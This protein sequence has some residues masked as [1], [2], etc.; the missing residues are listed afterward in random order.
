MSVYREFRFFSPLDDADAVRLSMADQHGRE[1]FT[2]VEGGYGKRWR[3]RRE[4][5]LIALEDAI[6][7]GDPPGEIDA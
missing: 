2:I 5:A 3:E 4:A 7:A 1:Y 6:E